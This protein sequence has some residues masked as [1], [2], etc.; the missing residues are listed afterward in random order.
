MWRRKKLLFGISLAIALLLGTIG[1]IT[2]AD[3]S[4]EESETVDRFE[5]I[6]S[7]VSNI[8]Q[9]KTGVSLDI[10][11]L[12]ESFREA[13]EDLAA[14]RQN[15]WLQHLVDEGII[16]REQADEYSEWWKA[17]PD[18]PQGVDFGGR[19]FRGIR[20]RFEFGGLC[21]PPSLD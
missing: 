2:L 17:R 1:G 11:A 6:Y 19:V 13:H 4:S 16:T 14:E 18:I 12:K 21:I 7:K 10:N 20:G 3:D 15:T 5:E 9:E 8:Y